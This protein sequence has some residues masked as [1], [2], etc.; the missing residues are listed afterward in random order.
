M[1]VKNVK[2]SIKLPVKWDENANNGKGGAVSEKVDFDAIPTVTEV[3][4][5]LETE[6]DESKAVEFINSALRS[7]AISNEYQRRLAQLKPDTMS[8]AERIERTVTQFIKL[9]MTPEQA[10]TQVLEALKNR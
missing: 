7:R 6:G 8:E 3:T 2:D 4:D 1:S 5:L 10:R 9:G